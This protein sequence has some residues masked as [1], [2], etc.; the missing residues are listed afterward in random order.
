MAVF[1]I[2]LTLFIII[3]VMYYRLDLMKAYYHHE[4]DKTDRYEKR[5]GEKEAENKKLEEKLKSISYRNPV[6]GIENVDYFIENAGS[7]MNESVDG[8]FTIIAISIHNIAEINKVFG[9]NEAD[10]IIR[11]VGQTL[12]K[13]MRKDIVGHIQSNVFAVLLLNN[14]DEQ[15]Q[16]FISS[17]TADIQNSNDEIYIEPV[18]GVYQVYEK[19]RTILEMINCAVLA[20]KYIKDIK[21]CNYKFYTKA[22]EAQFT[23]NMKMSQEMEQALNDNKFVMYL[24]PIVDLKTFR[25]HS[26]EALVRWEYPGKGVLSPYVFLPIFE[27]NQLVERLDYYM[28]EECCKTLRRWMDNKIQP[29]PIHMNISPIHLNNTKFIGILNELVQKYLVSKEYLVLEIPERGLTDT[30]YSVAEIMSQ[31]VENEYIICIDNFGSKHSPLNLL[32]DYPVDQVKIDRSFINSNTNSKQG[33]SILRYLVALA[34]D[35][36]LEVITEGVENI[37]QSNFL[38]EIG[39]DYA[40]G[41]FYSK[42][43]DVRAFDALSKSMV[44]KVFPTNEFY[45]TFESFEND[46]NVLEKMTKK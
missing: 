1:L 17:F 32:K 44:Q 37:E 40:Q 20:Q 30:T 5:M 12:K 46:L 8:K 22:L 27:S 24:Q 13:K 35:I 42:P 19:G 9:T 34:K 31:L 43:V 36:E 14:S 6:S 21:E 3:G 2:I 25:I 10:S 39:S 15:I 45:P 4:V 16:Q 28:W 7:R 33:A 29:V 41:F 11:F 26:A 38:A 18:F 23:E